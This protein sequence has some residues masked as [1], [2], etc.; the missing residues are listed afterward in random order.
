M[1]NLKITYLGT[2]RSPLFLSD[3]TVTPGAPRTLKLPPQ[4]YMILSYTGDVITSY[5]TGVIS[6][7]VTRGLLYAEMTDDPV[8]SARKYVLPTGPAGGGLGGTYPN[9]IAAGINIPG[10]AK[11]DMIYFDGTNWVLL[12][13]GAAGYVLTTHGV[14]MDPSWEVSSA[15][16]LPAAL[17]MELAFKV[18]NLANYKTFGYTGDDLTLIEIW[19]EPGMITKLFSK[20]LTYNGSGDLTQTVLTRISDGT[21][22]T[23]DYVYNGSGDL[24]SITSS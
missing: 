10:Q 23:R 22:L 20:V 6:E 16:G 14:G 13:P 8:I 1:A 11:G 15:A 12:V 18:A 2:G 3:I 9:P 17:E 5:T 7:Y 24:I 19:V 21:V 4:S